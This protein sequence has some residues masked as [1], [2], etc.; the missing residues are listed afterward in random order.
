MRV[1]VPVV[2]RDRCDWAGKP[3]G[4][5][6]EPQPTADRVA[7]L[8]GDELARCLGEQSVVARQDG[9]VRAPDAPLSHLCD[10]GGPRPDDWR[11]RTPALRRIALEVVPVHACVDEM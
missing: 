1:D 6:P 10:P 7:T 8:I 4:E 5:G 11:G 9:S 3:V 2:R